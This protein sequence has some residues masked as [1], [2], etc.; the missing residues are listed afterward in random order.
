MTSPLINVDLRRVVLASGT[1]HQY[2]YLGEREGPRLFPIMIGNAEANEIHRVVHGGQTA[3]PL[4]HQLAFDLIR[5]LGGELKAV[6]IVDLKEN[7]FFARLII[8]GSLG[9]VEIDARPSDA[10][11]LALRSRAPIRVAESVLD[12]ANETQD[13]PAD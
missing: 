8:E 1:D 9:E 13:P 7:T 3:R 4:T 6:H 11:A 12:A 5:G 2:I 10:I